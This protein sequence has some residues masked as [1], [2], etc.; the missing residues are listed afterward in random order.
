MSTLAVA[1]RTRTRHEL[2]PQLSRG[3][4]CEPACFGSASLV[5]MTAIVRV[6]A[7]TFLPKSPSALNLNP[8]FPSFPPLL[9]AIS[10]EMTSTTTGA[11]A[12][13]GFFPSR[14]AVTLLVHLNI[15]LVHPLVSA[16]VPVTVALA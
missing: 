9:A 3:T 8:P 2:L 13:T 1:I 14:L 5:A 10:H 11:L 15:S 4:R 12:I 16:L 7:V 6:L